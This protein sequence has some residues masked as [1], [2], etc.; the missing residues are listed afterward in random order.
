MTFYLLTIYLNQFPVSVEYSLEEVSRFK[1]MTMFFESWPVWQGI[2]WVVA[3]S[4]GLVQLLLCLHLALQGA[5]CH[6]NRC[7]LCKQEK[8]NIRKR[9]MARAIYYMEVWVF[10]ANL[11]ETRLILDRLGRNENKNEYSLSIWGRVVWKI[12][13]QSRGRTSEMN[14]IKS[15]M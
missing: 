12:T 1:H 11:A 9:S 7:E 14:T 3:F 6:V 4:A 15:L 13:W 8:K 5:S 2:E 10:G